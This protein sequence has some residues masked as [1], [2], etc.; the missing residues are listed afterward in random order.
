[1]MTGEPE[2]RTRAFDGFQALE[3]PYQG[4]DLSMVILL[5][6]RGTGLSDLEPRLSGERVSRWMRELGEVEPSNTI[7]GLPRFTAS[8]RIELAEVLIEMGMPSAFHNADFSGMTGS[9]GSFID[10]VIHQAWIEVTEEGTEAAAATAV[11][12]KRGGSMFL[13]DRPFLFLIR[14]NRTGSLLFLGRIVDPAA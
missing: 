12:M 1:M 7:I 5:P 11:V 10:E 6:D 3:L 13:V 4:G 14:E 2:V 9:R 8:Y